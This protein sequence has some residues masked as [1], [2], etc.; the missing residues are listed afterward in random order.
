MKL[1]CLAR[2]PLDYKGGIPEYCKN[3]YKDKEF[4]AEV[5]T[6]DLSGKLTKPLIRKQEGIK[7]TIFPSELKFGTIAVSL[8][9]LISIVRN[10]NKFTHSTKIFHKTAL[11]DYTF[12]NQNLEIIR[13]INSAINHTAIMSESN[14]ILNESNNLK[15]YFHGY[16]F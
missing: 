3:I 13:Q 6:Y 4:G 9:Y 2:A 5:Y 11:N 16:M 8:R 14:F 10:K 15:K 1:L 7:E 12:N